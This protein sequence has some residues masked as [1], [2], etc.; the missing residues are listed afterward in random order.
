[1]E[2]IVFI[3]MPFAN[4]QL[5][6]IGLT[7]LRSVLGKRFKDRLS[8][9]I[10]YLNQDFGHYMGVP[11][12]MRIASSG[13]EHTAGMGDWFFRQAA[14]PEADDN[15]EEY[16]QRYYAQRN[17]QTMAFINVV[18]EKR[19]GLR[20]FLDQLI[21]KYQ[22]DDS[23]IVGFTSMFAQ[24]VASFAMARR[25]K[26]RNPNLITV[27]G[28]ANCESPMGKE[29]VRHVD[30][31]DFVFSG[32]ALISFPQFV[33]NLLDQQE[34]DCHR[35]NGVFSKRNLAPK[36]SLMVLG[37]DRKVAEVGDE[38][39]I[40]QTVELD[41]QPFLN[42]F[43][44][45]FPLRRIKPILTYETSRGC[46]WGERAHC[47]FCGLNGASMNYRAMGTE[48]ALEQYKS[49][50]AYAD[51]CSRFECVDNIM[52][53]T[54][55]KEVLPFINTPPHVTIFYEVKADL[56]ED[57][58]RVLAAARVREIQ[59]GIESLATSTLKL[60]KKGTTVFQNLYLLRNC[61][62]YGVTPA[63]N[64]LIG[65]PGEGKE[66]YEKYVRD[67]PLLV[68][69]PPPSG[70][71]PVRF[72]RFSPYFT[73]AKAYN[74][75][76]KPLDF[77]NMTYPFSAESL[78]N[79]A[80]YFNDQ[81]IGAE[82]NITMIKWIGKIREKF[83]AWATRWAVVE[84]SLRPELRFMKKGENTVVYDTRFDKP[85]EHRI[86]GA[87]IEMLKQMSKVQT[88]KALVSALADIQGL[89]VERELAAL[90]EQK[91]IFQEGDRYMSLVMPEKAPARSH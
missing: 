46:W 13:Q 85:I 38:L 34:A 54:Y 90:Q 60:M 4:L 25:L 65:F 37:Q 47:T 35:I 87:G 55:I 79:L 74:L 50:F 30:C 68:H 22:L 91:L 3:N 11:T 15:G 7:Q 76:L 53:K 75:D 69:L 1:M 6:S 63:W 41:Y 21:D 23:L 19:A 72:D 70:V 44:K 73:Q 86:S 29:L 62:I 66:V 57:D 12:Y 20:S 14:F 45:N 10:Q 77:Y 58:V 89:D 48:K 39:D 17:D 49:L 88:V 67:L 18:K 52:P 78:A 32:P 9:D 82:Y 16:F 26:E 42:T 36:S 28:G 56:S 33:E 59:P 83:N 84:E 81:N 8:V 80:Y 71:F 61:L 5:P 64:L 40:N 43:A 51:Q 27:M 24:N 2:K 31:L